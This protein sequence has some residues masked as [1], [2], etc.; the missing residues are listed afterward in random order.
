M[1]LL[2]LFSAA[3]GKLTL[4]CP[5]FSIMFPVIVTSLVFVYEI[6]SE[7]LLKISLSMIST[8]EPPHSIPE[9]DLRF[10]SLEEAGI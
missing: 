7:A 9:G 10:C 4:F 2:C 8:C 5:L 6:P 1:L 3:S